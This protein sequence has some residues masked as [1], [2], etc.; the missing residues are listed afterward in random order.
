MIR[1]LQISSHNPVN[2]F[3]QLYKFLASIYIDSPALT[4]CE[5]G[6]SRA[7]NLKALHAAKFTKA[8]LVGV[9]F[10]ESVR[11]VAEQNV[12]YIP[13]IKLVTYLRQPVDVLLALSVVTRHPDKIDIQAAREAYKFFY[14]ML[15]PGGI[16][17]VMNADFYPDLFNNH[18][19]KQ[20]SKH[21]YEKD[22]SEGTSQALHVDWSLE[23]DLLQ[24]L[25][26][27][28]LEFEKPNKNF[29]GVADCAAPSET[30]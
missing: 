11:I 13:N 23:E 5:F 9:E 27:H 24:E 16:L 29:D 6:C 3:P 17:I 26:Q 25:E 20:L 19:F 30:E 1:Y 18:P 22:R 7:E 21:V 4:I 8:N 10:N 15:K 2:R 12:F 14:Q 28:T